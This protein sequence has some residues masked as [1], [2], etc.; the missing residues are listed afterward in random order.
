ME[1]KFKAWDK[2]SNKMIY[3]I[4]SIYHNE[5]FPA[6]FGDFLSDDYIVMQYTGYNDAFEKEIY[7]DDLMSNNFGTDKEVIRKIVMHNGTIMM[8]RIKG[9]S[10]LLKCIPLHEWHKLNFKVIGN[11]HILNED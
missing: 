10:T 1:P 9:N 8:E 5:G 4:E 11:I 3:E 2:F 7:F 6:S